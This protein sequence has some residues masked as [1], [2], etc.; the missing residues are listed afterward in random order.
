[1]RMNQTIPQ[2][3]VSSKLMVSPDKE[4]VDTSYYVGGDEGQTDQSQ[5]WRTEELAK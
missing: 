3:E 2:P 1:M 5:A 4:G